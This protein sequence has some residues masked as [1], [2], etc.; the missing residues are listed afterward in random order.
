MCNEDRV[1][2]WNQCWNNVSDYR[3]MIKNLKFSSYETFCILS[4]VSRLLDMDI[5]EVIKIANKCSDIKYAH[6]LRR[7]YAKELYNSTS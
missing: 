7:I 2:N 4:P 6:M 3:K 5:K 1:L